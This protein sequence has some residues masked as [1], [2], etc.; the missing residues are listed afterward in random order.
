MKVRFVP[1]LLV[2]AL[3][4]ISAF[5]QLTGKNRWMNLKSKNFNII[6]DASEKE[7]REV[8][9]K[10]EQFRETFR[11]VFKNMNLNSPT[12]T[13]V[14]VFRSSTSYRPF[15][16]KRPDGKPDEWIAGYFQPGEARN[17][18]TLSTEGERENTYGTIF[19]EYVH[20]L[21]DTN[22]GRSKIPAWF[23]E[24]I[25]EYYQTLRMVDNQIVFFGDL[26]FGHLELMRNAKMVPFRDFLSVSNYSLSG[27][28][29][30]RSVFYAQ[31]WAFM[32][33]LL[34]ANDRAYADGLTK[35]INLSAQNI[36]GEKAFQQAFGTDY[37]S[38][39]REF[40]KYLKQNTYVGSKL[41][42]E[43][44]LIFDSEM[45]MTPLSEADANAYLG[46]LLYHGGEYASAEKYLGRALELDSSSAFAQTSLGLVRMRQR[47]F[48]E[49]RKLLEAAVASPAANHYTHYSY[50]EVVSRE[51]M[52]EFGYV[53]NFPDANL[54]KMQ[55]SLRRSIEL[56]PDFA[57]SY[58]L[59]A[60]VNAVNGVEL[61]ESLQLLF[62]ALKV[63]P[64]NEYL[65]LLM[66]RIMMNQQKFAD[67]RKLAE[68]ISLTASNPSMKSEADQLLS[69][70]SQMEA[71]NKFN[72]QQRKS[73]EAMGVRRQ[74]MVARETISPEEAE[75][76]EAE[77]EI[78]NLNRIVEVPKVGEM[79]IVGRIKKIACA[80]GVVRYE[81]E[82]ESGPM[83]L[84]SVDFQSLNM[85]ILHTGTA[86]LEVG[87]N[88]KIEKELV[89]ANYRVQEDKKLKSAGVL[90]AISFVPA[91]F[92]KMTDAELNEPAPIIVGGPATD[93]AENERLIAAEQAE[94]IQKR[95]EL[96]EQSRSQSMM[97]QITANL[98]AVQSGELRIVGQIQNVECSGKN[99]V[100]IVVSGGQTLRLR[101]S[102]E[103][104]GLH[105]MSFVRDGV[106]RFECRSTFPGLQAVVTYLPDAK[107][108]GKTNGDLK[109]IEFVP[110]SFELQ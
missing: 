47:N 8:A 20:Y 19:H 66:A 78:R 45:L 91:S 55:A 59:L 63:K 25:A 21:M 16:P 75:R 83:L 5:G 61:D 97:D 74:T 87:C 92:R 31:A 77:R 4:S 36:E 10:L 76:L 33:F 102:P 68:R 80:G 104:Q 49:A 89:V 109:A 34:H 88:A 6:G 110:T 48:P 3:L 13:N 73:M 71:A 26:Q 22:L 11:V 82:T 29:H 72:E 37:S 35:F 50:A 90:T 12:E 105:F 15:K 27:G 32:H 53:T 62:K 39:E 30:S 65:I 46:D 24:G 67:A 94:L 58:R 70:M 18:I 9:T 107:P 106:G 64:G 85:Q 42:L 103:P 28:G 17:Y 1:V 38:M 98:R 81:F 108:K 60:W 54:K 43:Q 96:M 51:G 57:E 93:I 100:A 2:C 40:Q 7:L 101:V 23:N 99:M 79:Q 41:T 84:T 56:K 69:A 86:N 52:D 95:Q 14:V 44:K